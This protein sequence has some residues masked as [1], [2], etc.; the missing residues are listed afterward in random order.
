[1]VPFLDLKA[2]YLSIKPEID[3]AV[4]DVLGSTQ[5]V[6]GKAVSDFEE[7]FADYCHTKHAIACNS[8]TSAL[9]LALAAADIGEGDEVIIPAM[10]FIATAAAVDLAK[11]KP[12]FVDVDLV[13]GN[14][15][16]SGL[17]SAITP[18]TRALLP[19]HLHGQM[20]NM[21]EILAVAERH[22]LIVIED[23]AQ[24]HGAEHHGR[25]AGSYGAIGCYSFYP[26]KNLGA[27]GEGGCVVTS[28]DELAARLRMLRDWGQAEKY[29]HTLKG[30]NY[31][32]DGIQ[33][34]VLGVKMNYIEDWTEA[35]RRAAGHYNTLLSGIEGISLPVEEPGNR[36]VYHIYGIRVPADR[37]SQ[38]MERLQRQ[39][40]HSGLHYPIAVHLQPCYS[41]LGRKPGDFP[42]AEMFADQELSLP[43]FPEL[44]PAMAKSVSDSLAEIFAAK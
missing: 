10:T 30:F 41:E 40:I 20:A 6:L 24:A 3:A 23:A 43:M 13:T 1:M 25:R 4:L 18:R 35:R 34:A 12:V 15:D 39:G 11:A 37:R 2:Q 19:V 22:G 27:Y 16:I 26:G 32:M 14:L 31:R 44:T 38:I 21:S 28:D 42:A 17:E 29:I 7:I 33:G 5:F 36:H 8:G 9:H